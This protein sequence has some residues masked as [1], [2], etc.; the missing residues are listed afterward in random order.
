MAQGE[1]RLL[2]TPDF[3]GLIRLDSITPADQ[4]STTAKTAR[5]QTATKQQQ[6]IAQDTYDLF[7]TAMTAQGG[8]TIDQTAIASVQAQMN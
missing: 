8:L 6:S 1:V 2:D 3:T 5:D 7:T 4:T